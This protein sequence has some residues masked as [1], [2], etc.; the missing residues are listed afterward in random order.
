MGRCFSPS[1]SPSLLLALKRINKIFKKK[2]VPYKGEPEF[3]FPDFLKPCQADLSQ[4]S[5]SFELP[6][7]G[8]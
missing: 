4:S 2:L 1:L 8:L 6:A 7:L 5:P 3:Q